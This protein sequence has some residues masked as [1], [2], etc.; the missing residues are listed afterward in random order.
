MYC[1]WSGVVVGVWQALGQVP[2]VGGSVPGPS[3]GSQG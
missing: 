3:Y 1:S 2:V